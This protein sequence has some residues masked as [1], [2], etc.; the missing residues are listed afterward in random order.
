MAFIKLTFLVALISMLGQSQ[1]FSR[2]LPPIP[3]IPFP[4][5]PTSVI[6]AS[7]RAKFAFKLFSQISKES[8]RNENLFLSPISIYYALAM[9]RAGAANRS[10]K[11][12]DKVLGLTDAP[13]VDLEMKKFSDVLFAQ[14]STLKISNKVWQQKWFCFSRCRRFVKQLERDYRSGLGEVNFY[15]NPVLAARA[16]NNW[17]RIESRGRIQKL[18]PAALVSSSTR[19]ILTNVI[20]FK[21][22]WKTPFATKYT[23]QGQFTVLSNGNALKKKVPTMYAFGNFRFTHGFGKKYQLLE[24][25]YTKAG[26]S[27]LIILPLAVTDMQAVEDS[28]TPNKL[29]DMVREIESQPLLE[30]AVFMPKFR[31]ANNLVIADALKKLGLTDLFDP[32]LADLSNITGFKGMFVSSVAHE[33]FIKIDE[34]GTEASGATGIMSGDLSLTEIRINKAFIFAIRHAPTQSVI[35]AGKVVDPTL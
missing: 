23:H 27:M 1:V 5:I 2:L 34:Y 32:A 22:S 3:A 4:S 28:L 14:N 30:T 26:F 35:F 8:K 29:I 15:R 20:Y 16:I 25:P 10:K 11:Q 19:F 24:L 21:A 7:G 6:L 9:L 12:M 18:I 17:A 31:I 13:D 33:A